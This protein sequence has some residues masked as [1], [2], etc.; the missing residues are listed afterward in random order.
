MRRPSRCTEWGL[1]LSRSL[2]LESGIVSLQPDELLVEVRAGTTM[3]DLRDVL[4]SHGQRLRLPMIG[5]VGGAVAARRNGPYQADNRGLPNIVLRLFARDGEGREFRAG[6][7]TVKN[8]SG[9]D[10]VKVLVGS[11]GTLATI[12]QVTLRTEPIP[13]T[14]RW[15][16]GAGSTAAL[17]RP[18]VVIETEGRVFVNLE[19]HPADV[20]EQARLLPHFDEVQAPSD[21][22]LLRQGPSADARRFV[23]APSLAVCRR[24]KAA[25]DP[26][27]HLSPELSGQWGLL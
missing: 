27:N 2:S 17:Y 6:G 14:S 23:D 26:H 9:F 24:L 4:A 19:G 13:A 12:T 15:F 21:E 16:A 1:D 8:V 5:T 18:T 7:T 3:A 25:F 10:L 11:R 22:W 20:D